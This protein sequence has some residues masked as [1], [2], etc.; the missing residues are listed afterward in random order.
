MTERRARQQ[1]CCVGCQ[2]P[3][4]RSF[5]SVDFCNSPQIKWEREHNTHSYVRKRQFRKVVSC[6]VS[7]LSAPG[8][9]VPFRAGVQ[10]RNSLKYEGL[11]PLPPVGALLE[12]ATWEGSGP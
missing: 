2:G 6:S 3:H 12:A 9:L 11:F 4:T 7:L 1:R 8:L 5:I 10:F